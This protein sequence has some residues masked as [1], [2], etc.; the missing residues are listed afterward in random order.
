MLDHPRRQQVVLQELKEKLL[1][2]R[3]G[4]WVSNAAP[5]APVALGAADPEQPVSCS[6]APSISPTLWPQANALSLPHS[7][8]PG[9]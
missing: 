9:R 4:N 8:H 7:E 5:E 2:P 3:L 1:E 6:G